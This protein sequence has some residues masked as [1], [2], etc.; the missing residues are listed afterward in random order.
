MVK[1]VVRPSRLVHVK[2]MQSK[3]VPTVNGHLGRLVLSSVAQVRILVL[4]IS[5]KQHHLV[6][7]SVM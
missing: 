2:S 7:Y 3:T 1:V 4:V 6:V 5:P